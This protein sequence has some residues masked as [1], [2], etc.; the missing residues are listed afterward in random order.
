MDKSKKILTYVA[1]ASMS[2]SILLL[3]MAIF[4]LKVFEG[5]L[6]KILLSFATVAVVSAFSINALNILKTQKIVPYIS[7]GLLA[8][9]GLFAF[10]VFWTG[11]NS[12]VLN[13]IT[14]ILAIAT[15]LFCIVVSLNN[16][17]QSRYKV[18]QGIT[19]AVIVLIDI[20]LTLI[21]LGVKVFEVSGILEIFLVACL[22]AFGLLCAL[23]I[24]GKKKDA[25]VVESEYIKVQKH[26]YEKLLEKI[27]ELEIENAKLRENNKQ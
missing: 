27:K 17:I 22:L 2:V 15:V 16:K 7:L 6:L 13:K 20:V 14:G 21:I 26:E 3:I 4:G 23:A 9:S 12:V 11:F 25:G 1:V 24:L 5:T 10:I 8:L 19:Y 18:L